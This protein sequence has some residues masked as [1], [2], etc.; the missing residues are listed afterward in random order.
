[1]LLKTFTETKELKNRHFGF[2]ELFHSN[3]H[4]IVSE[5]WLSQA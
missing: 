1:M 4:V 2:Y 3:Y 5:I